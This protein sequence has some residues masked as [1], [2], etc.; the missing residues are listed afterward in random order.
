MISV[1][2]PAYNAAKLLPECLRALQAQTV[3]RDQFEVIVA[4]DG[5]T[6]ET[7]RIAA[8]L[9]ARVV[10]GTHGGPSMARNR[11]VAA[12]RG[13]IILFTD[14]DCSP[15]PDWI[16][17]MV[18]PIADGVDGVK[19]AY[20]NRQT[21]LLPRFVQAEFEEKYERLAQA[22][23]IDFV[24]TYAAAYRREVLERYGG[25]DPT[26]AL[27]SVEDID[28]SFRLARQG[29]RFVFAPSARVY[30]RHAD[31]LRSYLRR[32]YRYGVHR[33][34]VYRRYPDKV[35]GDSYTP[36][37][38]LV[39]IGLAGLIV[40]AAAASVLTPA[41]TSWLA[42]SLIAFG[43]TTVPFALRSARR[44]LG[45]AI[46]SPAL[47]LA[48]SLAQ[49]CGLVVGAGLGLRSWVWEHLIHRPRTAS[50]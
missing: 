19:G 44:D 28:L 11:G 42:A 25:F 10:G 2:I 32:K 13:E 37:V 45:V 46:A 20:R 1:V 8:A 27:P 5:S 48:R 39:Q 38:M 35:I 33:V 31:T 18:A 16:E 41:A 50:C 43:L 4:D 9:G 7:A 40:V 22:S 29:C 6:D 36:R 49:G 47:L 21:G 34:Q 30:H 15:L 17:Q 12:A 3:P 14:S 26:F 24:D 23:Q